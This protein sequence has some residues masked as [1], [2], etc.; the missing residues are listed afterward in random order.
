VI[1]PLEKAALFLKGDIALRTHQR[2]Q[3]P[4]PT[5][6]GASSPAWKLAPSMLQRAPRKESTTPRLNP[7]QARELL[8]QIIAQ[9]RKLADDTK[10]LTSRSV[11]ERRKTTDFNAMKDMAI[12]WPQGGAASREAPRA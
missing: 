7:D 4:P 10:K 5:A 2:R 8:Q 12:I 11:A 1:P 6:V 3:G 9:L